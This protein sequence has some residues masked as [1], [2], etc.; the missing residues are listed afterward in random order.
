MKNYICCFGDKD[1]GD[2]KNFN[3]V[4]L[5]KKIVGFKENFGVREKKYS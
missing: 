4:A 5:K 3:H 1:T 2:D